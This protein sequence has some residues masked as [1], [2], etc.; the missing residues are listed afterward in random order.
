MSANKPG[1][2]ELLQ[3]QLPGGG[4]RRKRRWRRAPGNPTS[5]GPL[6][7]FPGEGGLSWKTKSQGLKGNEAQ[8]HEYFNH[9]CWIKFMFSVKQ[10]WGFQAPFLHHKSLK[11]AAFRSTVKLRVFSKAG[12]LEFIFLA[13]PTLQK[14]KSFGGMRFSSSHL[15]YSH[16]STWVDALK[17]VPPHP[18][19]LSVVSHPR[20]AA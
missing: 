20:G 12:T 6:K 13:F 9:Y 3:A 7:Q 2:K 4:G 11:L 5:S 1:T 17:G 18:H 10:K 8:E 19:P 16:S 15:P 14:Q